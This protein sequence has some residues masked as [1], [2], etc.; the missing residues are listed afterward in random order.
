MYQFIPR[1]I[2]LY[3]ESVQRIDR[4]ELILKVEISFSRQFENTKQ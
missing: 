2:E 1:F 4:F 3:T